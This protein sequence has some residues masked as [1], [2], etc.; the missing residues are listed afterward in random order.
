MS[1]LLTPKNVELHAKIIERIRTTA[2]EPLALLPDGYIVASS[3]ATGHLYKIDDKFNLISTYNTLGLF[4][5]QSKGIL[6]STGTLIIY[7]TTNNKI[8]RSDDT[9]YATFTEVFALRA[10]TSILHSNGWSKAANDNIMFGEYSTNADKANPA[11]QKVYLGTNDGATWTEVQSFN[12]E[13]A[14]NITHIHACC[15]D[16]YDNKF[17]VCTGDGSEVKADATATIQQ[18]CRVYRVDVDG[19]NWDLIGTGSQLWR[20]VGMVFTPTHAMW[21]ID[22]HG[23]YG[24]GDV[25][26]SVFCKVDKTTKQMTLLSDVLPSS[27][28]GAYEIE[29]DT[30]G[31]LYLACDNAYDQTT[32]YMNIWSYSSDMDKWDIAGSIERSHNSNLYALARHIMSVGGDR[33]MLTAGNVRFNETNQGNV[34]KSFDVKK[35]SVEVAP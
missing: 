3:I 33:I 20:V 31:T 14:G 28:F 7:S 1:R 11:T 17:W 21:G 6:L 9:T 4:A 32:P 8:Y 27:M 19:T 2:Y 22:G 5:T 26:G 35:M 18:E 10:N 24:T 13:G 25:G 29:T 30:Y 34:S 12:R 23:Y 15:Y 16:H